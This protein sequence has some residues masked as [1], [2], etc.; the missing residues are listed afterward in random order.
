MT[1]EGVLMKNIFK[2]I[3]VVFLFVIIQSPIKSSEY[4]YV[5]SSYNNWN[6]SFRL[7]VDGK[8]GNHNYRLVYGFNKRL[9]GS[10]DYVEGYHSYKFHTVHVG[11]GGEYD[12]TSS[13]EAGIWAYRWKFHNTDNVRYGLSW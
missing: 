8:D 6:S 12:Y 9:I 7:Y 1:I 4:K 5:N 13:S 10:D 11:T 2:I 3:L